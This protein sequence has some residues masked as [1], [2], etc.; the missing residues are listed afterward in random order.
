MDH[1]H[2][3]IKVLYWYLLFHEEPLASMESFYCTKGILYSAKSFFV[4]F[5]TLRTNGLH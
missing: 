2:L 5:F 1:T 4:L 3:K